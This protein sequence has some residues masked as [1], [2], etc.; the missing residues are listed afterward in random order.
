MKKLWTTLGNI[1]FWL[2]W[3]GLYFY[4]KSTRRC[5][6]IVEA[7]KQVLLVMG[8]LGRQ[9]WSLPGGGKHEAESSKQAAIREVAEETGLS[10]STTQLR[11]L[12]SELRVRDSGFDFYID[13]FYCRLSKPV[14]PTNQ[15]FEIAAAKWFPLDQLQNNLRLDNSSRSVLEA[16]LEQEHLLD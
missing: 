5:R 2:A 3:P 6:V 12:M 7:D 9:T 14:K 16:W 10:L 11:P 13:A 8:W 1:C 15:K 4:L